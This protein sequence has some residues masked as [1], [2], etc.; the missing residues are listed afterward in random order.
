LSEK[1]KSYIAVSPGLHFKDE[2]GQIFKSLTTNYTNSYF[3]RT[4]D[5]DPKYLGDSCSTVGYTYSDTQ[6][7]SK[8]VCYI[9]DGGYPGT[10]F[11]PSRQ[12]IFELSVDTKR[13][14]SFFIG[15]GHTVNSGEYFGDSTV[16]N[17]GTCE[18]YYD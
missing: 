5:R 3:I 9:F 18:E 17:I 1:L 4:A 15:S 14:V 2:T 16:V 8:I 11:D 12:K 10:G 6:F 7:E 13:Y